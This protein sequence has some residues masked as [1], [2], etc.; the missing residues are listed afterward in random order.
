MKS[1]R[2]LIAFATTIPGTI[3]AFMLPHITEL[4]KEYDIIVYSNFQI[5]AADDLRLLFKGSP[6]RLV[7][8]AF[9][10]KIRPLDDLKSWWRLFWHLRRDRPASLHSMMPKTGL[11]ANTAGMLARVPV[12]IHMFTGQVWAS[13]QGWRRQLLKS[14][15]RLTAWSA[16]HILTDSP[17]QRDYLI[18][19]GFPNR[20]TVLGG[21]SVSGVDLDRFKPDLAMRMQMRSAYGIG[22]NDLVFGFLGR[23]N[24]DKGVADLLSAFVSSDLPTNCHLMLV[25]PDEENLSQIVGQIN[26]PTKARIHMCGHTNRPQDYLS[27]FDVYCLPS[28]REGFGT[29]VIEAAACGVP[30]LVSRIYGLTDAVQDNETGLFH[31]SGDTAAIASGLLQFATDMQLRKKLGDAARKRVEMQFKQDLLVSEMSDFYSNL[32]T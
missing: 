20:I 8:V 19:N 23:M 22:E 24:R 11:V 9:E 15:D 7:H 6:V 2:S 1:T 21:G 30:A 16:N 26:E 5:D 17:S 29:S 32:I 13:E 14:L 10:R 3:R 4:I 31:P 25:G 28:Y 27:A 18:G 12:R